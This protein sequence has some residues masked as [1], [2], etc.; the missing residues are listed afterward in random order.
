MYPLTDSIRADRTRLLDE[1]N[2]ARAR[3]KHR[4][5]ISLL[6]HVLE[7]EPDDADI[8]VR[9]AELLAADGQRFEAWNLFRTAG[10][11]QLRE[12]RPV[13]S[14]A[15]FREAT[16]CLP[17]EFEA[18]RI[19]AE[20]ERKLGRSEDAQL[21]LRE[22]RRQFRSRFDHAQATLL[23]RMVREIDP[24][25][26]EVVLDLARLYAQ[27]DQASRALRLLEGLAVRSEGTRLRAVRFAQWQISHSFLHMRLWLKTAFWAASDAERRGEELAASLRI[28]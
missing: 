19:T 27:T 8:S 26:H 3:G 16:R 20:L 11:T 14:L 22:A 2:R 10:K 28:R 13:Q 4:R 23:L 18:W 7:T 17:F 5:A 1:A 21:T 25:D 9:L 12:R 15:I 6:R 24:W